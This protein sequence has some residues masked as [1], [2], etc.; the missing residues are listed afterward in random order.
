MRKIF[1]I[2]LL[3]LFGCFGKNK[4]IPDDVLS[5]KEMARVMTEMHVLEARIFKLYVKPDSAEVLFDHYEELL[6]D[7]LQVSKETYEKS[8][9][10]YLSD[11]K[12]YEKVYEQVVDTLLSRQKREKN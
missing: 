12:N 2:A 3:T 1:F 9:E 7:S 8:L 6:L 10:F 11:A 4:R 5:R